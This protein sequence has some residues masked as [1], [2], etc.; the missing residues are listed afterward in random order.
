MI[1]LQYVIPG[2]PA[3][4]DTDTNTYYGTKCIFDPM[5]GIHMFQ[6]FRPIHD[7]TEQRPTSPI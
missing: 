1:T 5:T 3:G 2:D 6:R 4:T 7:S